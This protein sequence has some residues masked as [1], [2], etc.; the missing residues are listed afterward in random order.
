M[1][2]FR[3]GPGPHALAVAMAGVRMGERL[4]AVGGGTPGMF[5]A[6]AAKVGLTGRACAV[7]GAEQVAEGLRQAAAREGVLVE[8]TTAPLPTLPFDADAFD[9]VLVDATGGMPGLPAG[10]WAACLAEARRVLRVGGRSILVERTARTG[11][12]ALFGGAVPAPPL[13]AGDAEAAF[14][15][16]GFSPVRTLAER[17]GLLF[18]EGLK[19]TA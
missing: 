13:S 7:A 16:A 9:L 11:L 4:L 18:V 5:A 14:R 8:V 1:P 10:Q 6:L 2:I 17:E 3:K 15:T 19:R 12:G